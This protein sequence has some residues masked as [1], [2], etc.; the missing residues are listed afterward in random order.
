MTDPMIPTAALPAR[1]TGARDALATIYTW[2][3]G[4]PIELRLAV[5]SAAA[6]IGAREPVGF[7]PARPPAA[8]PGLTVETARKLC[9]RAHALLVA[10]I[11][12]APPHRAVGLGLAARELA[13]ALTDPTGA[14]P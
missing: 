5:T 10:E 8:D 6:E 11:T 9:R 1:L 4:L 13:E 2:G 3:A 14:Q 7:P 12:D